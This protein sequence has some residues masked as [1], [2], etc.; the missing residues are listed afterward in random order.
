MCKYLKSRKEGKE[1]KSKQTRHADFKYLKLCC[2][3]L[4]S[5]EPNNLAFRLKNFEAAY[6]LKDKDSA[7]EEL[8]YI[9]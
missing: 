6:K 8:S 9:K 3:E 1:N 4:V 5:R 7:K 2:E